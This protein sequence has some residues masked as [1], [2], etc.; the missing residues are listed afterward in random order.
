MLKHPGGKRHTGLLYRLTCVGVLQLAPPSRETATKLAVPFPPWMPLSNVRYSVPSGPLV[1]RAS[2]LFRIGPL[3]MRIGFENERP[4]SREYATST[5]ECDP[6]KPSNWTH[7]MYTEP[8]YGLPA[9]L[10]MY[11]DSWSGNC[12]FPPRDFPLPFQLDT[13]TG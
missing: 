7:V 3:L 1:T 12:P 6:C 9:P 2:W 4:P 5:G 11:M 8:R 13:R 10:S